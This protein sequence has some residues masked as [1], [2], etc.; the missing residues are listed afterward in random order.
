[1][2]RKFLFSAILIAG[3]LSVF[4]FTSQAVENK[5]ERAAKKNH[6]APAP[7]VQ[8][9]R[10]LFA[11]DAM[12]HTPQISSARCKNGSLDFRPLF[13]G[14]K[15]HFD[16]ADIAIV[17]FETTIS[18]NSQYSGY[19]C[20]SS[21]KQYA[22]ALAWLGTDVAVLANNHCC[23]NGIIGIRSTIAKL[24][25]LGIAHTGVFHNAEE[26]ERNAILRLEHNGI[27]FAIVNY[28]YGT[29]GNPV[30]RGCFVNHINTTQIANDLE[31]ASKDSDCVIA[32]MHWGVEYQQQPSSEQRRLA[33]FLHSHGVDLVI[34]SHPHVV[35]PYVA[36]DSLITLY[37]L[38]NFI[39]NQKKPNTDGGLLAEIEVEKGVDGVCK[40]SLKV[41]PVWVK[42]PGHRLV[43]SEHDSEV[44]MTEEQRA[45]Y[46]YF[47]S[48]TKRLLE[49]GVKF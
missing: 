24:D 47:L 35:Q 23:D 12:C 49:K 45:R 40:Y 11:G 1:M 48:N 37:S 19:P 32:C 17:N 26:R 18:P 27:K 30:P 13:E 28:T 5:R 21:P 22:D 8:R 25:S 10:L 38:G 46:N 41:I 44:K 14:V 2:K 36:T 39:S 20:F 4:A 43:S 33:Q 7:K 29:N 34:G 3:I 9:A 42:Y 6:T 16:Q 15:P 31:L